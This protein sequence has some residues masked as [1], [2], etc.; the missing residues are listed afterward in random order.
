MADSIFR[1][2]SLDRVNSPEQ[3]NDYIKTS[4]PSVW[5]VIFSIL[6][7]L[8]SVFVWAAF[9]S[10]DTTVSMGGVAQGNTVTCFTQDAGGIQAGSEVRL[11]NA[12]GTVLSVSQK[13][14]SQ[15]DA[16]VLAGGD[17]YT[18]Y[19]LDL[20]PWNYVVQIAV[21]GTVAEGYLT[22]EIVTETISPMAFV[23]G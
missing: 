6:I 13:P 23:L 10:L 18:L 15:A 14:I 1:K 7:L 2:Q 11:G 4:K 19:C 16:A 3:L 22:A 20:A 8:S 9:G 5:L 21:D 12:T 17:E